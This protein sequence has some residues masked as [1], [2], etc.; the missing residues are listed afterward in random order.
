MD[1]KN[2]QEL[3]KTVSDTQITC[4][5]IETDDIRIKMEKKQAQVVVERVP[6]NVTHIETVTHEPLTKETIEMQQVYTKNK[7][8]AVSENAVKTIPDENIFIV[9]SP[10]VGTMYTS[11]SAESK[12]FVKVGSIVKVGDTLCILEAMKLMNEIE[13]EVNGEVLEVLVS[14]EDMVEY[15]QPLFKIIKK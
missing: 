4:F 10:I 7:E 3:I 8:N 9:K 6:Q 14:N 12:N 15:G 5:E 2:I 13:S 11:P 1:Y